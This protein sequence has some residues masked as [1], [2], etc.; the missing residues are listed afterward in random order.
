[1][2]LLRSI[3]TNTFCSDN[4]QGRKRIPSLTQCRWLLRLHV[5]YVY[6]N[7]QQE[8]SK[9]CWQTERNE[10]FKDSRPFCVNALNNFRVHWSS[11]WKMCEILPQSDVQRVHHSAELSRPVCAIVQCHANGR[12][13]VPTVT[14]TSKWEQRTAG[15][16]RR[17]RRA[18]WRR[19]AA[20]TGRNQQ[21][22]LN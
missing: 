14:M 12:R 13:P 22:S 8:A 17:F 3:I 18:K 19:R 5:I 7:C 20:T 4:C 9:N 21:Q 1:M 11:G 16:T 2:I 6:L 15:W 10:R